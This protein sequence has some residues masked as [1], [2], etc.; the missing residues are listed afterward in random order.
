MQGPSV[1]RSWCDAGWPA[2][3]AQ[4][5]GWYLVP[6]ILYDLFTGEDEG[7]EEQEEEGQGEEEAPAGGEEGPGEQQGGQR[8]GPTH[9]QPQQQQGTTKQQ[10]GSKQRSKQAAGG[11]T[12][13]S[14]KQASGSKK[15]KQREAGAVPGRGPGKQQAGDNGVDGA[16]GGGASPVQC[17][18]KQRLLAKLQRKQGAASD[19]D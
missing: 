17:K 2:A 5:F 14:G 6:G 18:L 12:K 11:S 16:N 3:A 10:L 4:V 15:R 19:D 7:E 9:H 8:A 1:D 13:S